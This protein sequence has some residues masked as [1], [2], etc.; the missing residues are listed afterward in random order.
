MC[1]RERQ[2]ERETERKILE[3]NGLAD[4]E[5]VQTLVQC[6]RGVYMSAL[7][8]TLTAVPELSLQQRVR[9]Y[10]DNTNKCAHQIAAPFG[11]VLINFDFC[12]FFRFPSYL[13]FL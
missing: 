1:V 12:Q 9:N 8:D 5:P 11:P 13:L 6:Y 3:K 10:C 7:Y 4:E 2:R